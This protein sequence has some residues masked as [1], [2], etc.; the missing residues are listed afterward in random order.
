MPA[1]RSPIAPDRPA[2][3]VPLRRLLLGA[4]PAW[5]RFLFAFAS[6]ASGALAMAPVNFFPIM[7]VA[8]GAAVWLIDGAVD[9]NP[10]FSGPALRRVA[11]LG[12]FWGFGYFVAGLWWL[13]AAFLVD[14]AQW[15][16]ALPLG[17]VGLPAV[18]AFFPALGFVLARLLWSRTPARILAL[19]AGLGTTEYLRGHI[20]T[21]FPW[22]LLGMALCGRDD[23]SQFASIVGIDGMTFL[24]IAIFAA[25]A[26]WTDRGSVRGRL[27][28]PTVFAA[29]ALL[30][31]GLF[32]FVRLPDGPAATVPNV[33][34]GL[35]Q[36]NLTDDDY[37][38]PENAGEIIDNYLALSQKTFEAPA[39]APS[40][41]PATHVIWPESAFPLILSRNPEALQQIDSGLPDD[42]PLITGAARQGEKLPGAQYPQYFNALQ[43][44]RNG[45]I[46]D[47]YDK[48]HLV[49]FGEYLPADFLLRAIGLTQFVHQIG[50]FSAGQER[51]LLH[52]PGLPPIAPL[53]CYEAIF[54]GAVMPQG[55]V[56]ERPGLFLNVSNDSWFGRTWGPYQHLA[57]AR[58][59]SVEEGIPLVRVA[60]TGVS[61]VAD[62]YGRILAQS[63]LGEEA[64][65]NVALPTALPRTPFSRQGPVFIA[66]IWLVALAGAVIGVL[67]RR[68]GNAAQSVL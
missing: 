65:L 58:L 31:L 56:G 11:V 48:V 67:A 47:S 4:A 25:P 7:I 2:I 5:R 43:V 45:E 41:T 12:W 53:I 63:K 54:S 20:L 29:F 33:R 60:N 13:G 19:S 17:V 24:A 49:P 42:M 55:E 51:H 27:K 21:G 14:A 52:A 46:V 38:R 64:A 39:N 8:L 22:N 50:G 16:W 26:T 36:P 59:R 68:A 23:L 3:P 66:L 30:G 32:G 6:G 35:I 9:E 44:V 57:Q 37:F 15:A 61:A 1:A 62:A 34:L 28:L 10:A 18:L 40:F